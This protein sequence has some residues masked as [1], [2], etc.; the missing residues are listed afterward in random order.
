[1]GAVALALSLALAAGEGAGAVSS[2][3]MA[4]SLG[5]RAVHKQMPLQGWKD[6]EARPAA[7]PKDYPYR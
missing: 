5:E 7:G 1:M 2:N 4:R 6:H 3:C